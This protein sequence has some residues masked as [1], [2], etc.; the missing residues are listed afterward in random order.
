MQREHRTNPWA[1]T[2]AGDT[3]IRNGRCTRCY[4]LGAWLT[5]KGV[6]TECPNLQLGLAD[7]PVLTDEARAILRAGRHLARRGI[8]AN[9]LSFRLA[10]SL[11]LK[12]SSNDP[13]N[14]D[15]LIKQHFEW[16]R[17]TK[18]RMLAHHIEE[19][20]G[21]WLL[22]VGSRKQVP[23][24]Y[25]IITDER[26]FKEWVTRSMAAPIRQLTTIHACA[27]ANFPVF[28]EQLELNFWTDMREQY[29]P[30]RVEVA[31]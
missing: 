12:A 29:S 9:D 23:H 26:D 4:S 28:A 15:D 10:R 30:E 3:G 17:S 21:L 11:A 18:L 7:H 19:L 16:A 22:P 2:D 25:W 6:I 5:P 27:R 1:E 13:A 20:R 31:E 8:I 14:R 24:G